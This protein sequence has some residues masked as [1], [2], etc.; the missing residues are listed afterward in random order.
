[1]SENYAKKLNKNLMHFDPTFKSQAVMWLK[2]Q[3]YFMND[4]RM[5]IHD[6]TVLPLGVLSA[7]E[8]K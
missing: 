6:S 5:Y 8:R 2:G 3:K 4:Q 1:M 7:S